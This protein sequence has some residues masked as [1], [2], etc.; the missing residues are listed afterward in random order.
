MIRPNLSR[1]RR[2]RGRREFASVEHLSLEAVAAFVDGELSDAASHRARVHLVHC[3]ECRGEIERQ[4]GAS[5]W[6]RGSNITEE[7]RAPHDLLARLAGI[8]AAPVKA[9]P[10]AEST[11]TPGPECLLDKV[12]M[13][14]RAVKRNQGH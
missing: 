10:D 7:V 3:A 11:P 1:S 8:P 13:I 14:L 2:T 12:E 4:R 6:L 5:E 9:G